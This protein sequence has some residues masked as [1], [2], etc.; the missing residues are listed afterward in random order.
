MQKEIEA[1]YI[2]I[3]T[4]LPKTEEGIIKS[5]GGTKFQSFVRKN[6]SK[7]T[8]KII[9]ARAEAEI[10]D[11]SINPEIS[12]LIETVLEKVPDKLYTVAIVSKH[13]HGEFF[14][15]VFLVNKTT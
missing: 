3:I 14:F 2:F 9:R 7:D 5:L 11:N 8:I 12:E 13:R 10:D 6:V 1:E 15:A 4:F